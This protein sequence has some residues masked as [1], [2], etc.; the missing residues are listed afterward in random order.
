MALLFMDGFDTYTAEADLEKR[1]STDIFQTSSFA[2]ITSAAGR[3]GGNGLRFANNSSI[4]TPL[5]VNAGTLYAGFWFVGAASGAD[6]NWICSF[7]DGATAQVVLYLNGSGK[8]AAYRGFATALLG[9]GT[10]TI[11]SGVGHY[12]ELKV[13]FHGSTGSLEVRV[14]GT[15]DLSLT[16]LNTAPS[17]NAYANRFGIGARSGFQASHDYDDVYVCDST[18]SANN[19][20]LG[21][22]RVSALVPTGAGNY[23][24]WTPSTGS[25]WQNVDDGAPNGDTDYNSDSTTGHRDSFVMGDLPATAATVLAVQYSL[26][27]RKDDA[28]TRQIAPFVRIG[29]TDY[30]GTTVSVS[31]SYDLYR[32]IHETSP[33]SSVAWTVSEVNGMEYGYKEVA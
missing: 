15:T 18:G 2:A 30:D 1:W 28:G 27:A 3:N 22:V 4:S 8:I 14:D 6:T 31:S 13:V 10:R 5:G 7:Q 17:G 20:F 21:D 29:G 11:T 12:I 32:E 25:N 9:T 24:Q 19:N 23:T 16:G 33:A 26:V